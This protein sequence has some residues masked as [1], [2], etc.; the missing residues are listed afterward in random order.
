MS[1]W[2]TYEIEDAKAKKLK[3]QIVWIQDT[4][5]NRDML[6]RAEKQ[7]LVNPGRQTMICQRG[8]MI[9]LWVDPVKICVSFKKPKK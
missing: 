3:Q 2:K 1:K 6:L 9:S 8:S 7:V 4:P 5:Q